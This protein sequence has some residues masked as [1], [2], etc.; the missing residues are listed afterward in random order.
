MN[1]VIIV[2]SCCNL[3]EEFFAENKELIH[4]LNMPVKLGDL[5]FEDDHGKT[6]S[7]EEFYQKLR[8]GVVS[9]TSLINA[10][11][12]YDKFQEL[13]TKG[14]QILYIGFSSGMSGTYSSSNIAK[15]MF[16]QDYPD[17]LVECFD[18]LCA[19]SG[20]GALI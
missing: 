15:E 11:T 19:S 9:S 14:K 10:N 13:H 4:V 1:K 3:P 17:A 20:Y 12:F 18:S 16:L 5:D 2:D 8:E 7:N 6:V